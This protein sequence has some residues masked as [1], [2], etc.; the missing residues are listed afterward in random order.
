MSI[1][2]KAVLFAGC[3]AFGLSMIRCA[4]ADQVSM[5]NGERY[6]GKIVALSNETVVVQSEV[7]G[8]LK[9]PKSKIA[10]ITFGTNAVMP[11][12]QTPVAASAQPLKPAA[13]N[14]S[15]DLT[16]AIN[17]LRANPNAMQQVQQ[18]MLAG[19]DPK[20]TEMFNQMMGGLMNGSLNVDDIRKQ[21]KSAA[22]QLRAAKK[23]L[24]DD[25]G[26]AV[27]GYLAVLDGFLRETASSGNSAT[28]TL[29]TPSKPKSTQLPAG[30]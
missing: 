7:L 13:T 21:A 10:S 29:P 15:S 2:K 18:Q 25:T 12:V 26:F 16:A 27:D 4:N 5:Q 9:V 6:I 22:D 3:C 8:T 19:A 17:Q 24:G 23:E 11:T 1:I 30:E 28:N 20:A 14:S